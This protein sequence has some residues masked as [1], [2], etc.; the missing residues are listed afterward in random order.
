MLCDLIIDPI[1]SL[2]GRRR[3]DESD[4]DGGSSIDLSFDFVQVGPLSMIR[5]RKPLCLITSVPL[6]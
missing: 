5:R 6:K 3:G 2:P 4:A 1:T